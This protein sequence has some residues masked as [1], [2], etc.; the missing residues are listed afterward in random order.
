MTDK[1][2][3]KEKQDIVTPISPG[4]V[5]E[6]EIIS[7]GRSAVYLDL[8]PQGTGVIRGREF[9]QVKSAL[10]DLEVGDTLTGEIIDVE[11]E[12]GYREVSIKKAIRKKTWNDLE[13]KKEDNETLEVRVTGA[14]TGGLLTKINDIQAFIPASQLSVDHFPRVKNAKKSRIREKLQD[15]VGEK[16]NVRILNLDRQDDKLILSEKLEELKEVKEALKQYKEGDVVEGVVSGLA[17]FG[18][19]ITFGKHHLEGLIHISELD[20]G[21]V[22]DP[23]DIVS[24]G[25]KIKAKI[26]DISEDRVSLSLKRMKPKKSKSS[27]SS[28]KEEDSKSEKESQD[29]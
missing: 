27:S 15:L 28:K 16:L 14:N 25:D 21:L 26:V 13:A 2:I 8:G 24:K 19:F 6:G 23:R 29:E 20:W 12:Q 4:D 5:I 17:D 9:Y 11:N 22:K 3:L 18:A 7:F 1:T 10:K